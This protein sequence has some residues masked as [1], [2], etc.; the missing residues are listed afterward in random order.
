M[1]VDPTAGS[2]DHGRDELLR[3]IST[4]KWLRFPCIFWEILCHSQCSWCEGGVDLGMQTKLTWY[5][6]IVFCSSSLIQICG[7]KYGKSSRRLCYNLKAELLFAKT[8]R[9]VV[10]DLKRRSAQ[11][12]TVFANEERDRLLKTRPDL[13]MGLVTRMVS[14]ERNTSLHLLSFMYSVCFAFPL[15]IESFADGWKVEEFW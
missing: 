3:P 8:H 2:Y 12:F 9:V 5:I 10:S 14:S 15:G 4:I 6:D 1:F 13:P 7:V 11:A